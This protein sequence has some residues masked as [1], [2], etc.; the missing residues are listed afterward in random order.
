M[1]PTRII[2]L[3]PSLTEFVVDVGAGDALIGRT[4]FCIH[5]AYNVS[6]IPIVGGTKNPRIDKIKA[7]QP[8]L[9]IMNREENRREDA[10]QIEA[11]APVLMTDISTIDEAIVELARIGTAI[12][13]EDETQRL[14]DEIQTILPSK[15]SFSPVRAAYLIWRNPWM[16]VG[17]STYIDDVLQRFGF[18]NVFAN[19]SR[20][21]EITLEQLDEAKPD[22][23][24]LSSEPFPFKQQHIDEIKN[25]ISIDHILTVDGEW[26]SWYGSRM[27]PAF[28][29]IT[30]WRTNMLK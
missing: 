6:D 24:L 2:S 12:G 8:D 27:L 26:F 17:S 11:F 21:P 13:C 7:I 15:D 18:V 29:N 16:A 5:P 1:K 20:Y 19:M 4:R 22:C 14:L 28:Q 10:E 3:V 23:V 25:A 30:L 9:V